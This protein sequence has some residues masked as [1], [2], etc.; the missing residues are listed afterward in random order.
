MT[1]HKRSGLVVIVVN[2]LRIFPWVVLQMALMSC[3]AVQRSA[4]LADPLME[5]PMPLER[6]TA[7]ENNAAS[8]PQASR[9]SQPP[10]E[11]A[12]RDSYVV[13]GKRYQIMEDSFQ[14][15][16]IGIASWYGEKFHGR[17]TAS[18]E[19]YDMYAMS[20]AHKALPLPTLVRVT[21]LDNGAKV[22][23]RV[24][25]RGPFHDDRLIDLSFAAAQALGFASRGTAPV[26]VEAIDEINHPDR[27][28]VE[29]TEPP[30]Y[31][32]T[33]AFSNRESA[34]RMIGAVGR[35]MHGAGLGDIRVDILESDR[36]P[37]EAALYK[38]WVGPIASAADRDEL[39]RVFEQGQI[40]KPI[41]VQLTR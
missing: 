5:R 31:L 26:V 34:E 30:V 24:N 40:G 13:M 9:T 10:L 37:Q 22:E 38:V 12:P 33:G 41:A 16:E 32:Q 2:M 19:D 14:Y 17:L 39:S 25:D 8:P 15:R 36:G 27:M 11:R 20:A 23:V 28:V 18:G 7:R 21:N 35:L 29:E 6:D 1:R 4:P 3:A